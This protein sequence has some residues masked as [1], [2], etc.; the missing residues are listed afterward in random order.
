MEMP[1]PATKLDAGGTYVLEKVRT[2]VRRSTCLRTAQV[3]LSQEQF[4]C[5]LPTIRMMMS[6]SAAARTGHHMARLRATD[7]G[8]NYIFLHWY[9]C[10]NKKSRRQ[11]G[12]LGRERARC[13]AICWRRVAMEYGLCRSVRVGSA[14][15]RV[16]GFGTW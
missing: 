13:A 1:G 4:T 3:S 2:S 11:R 15:R 8:S 12:H 7:H 10:V 16:A 9:Y 6:V 5:H 14:A